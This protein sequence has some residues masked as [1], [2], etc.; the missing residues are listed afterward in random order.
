VDV[1]ARYRELVAAQDVILRALDEVKAVLRNEAA[2]KAKVAFLYG[3]TAQYAKRQDDEFYAALKERWAANASTLKI[4][5][6]FEQDLK[7]FKVKLFVFE[8][9]YLAGRL[10]SGKKWAADFAEL[11]QDITSRLLAE[12]SQLL[13]L[14]AP[15]GSSVDS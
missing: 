11:A 13:P 8:E 3:T 5:E 9:K 14:L 10:N 12:Q 6:F 7:Y 2:S 1:Q 4:I 15:P